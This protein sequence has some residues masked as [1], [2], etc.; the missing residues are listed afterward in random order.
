MPTLL[1][2]GD[3]LDNSRSRDLESLQHWV[4]FCQSRELFHFVGP[5]RGGSEKD[6]EARI[7][8]I[9]LLGLG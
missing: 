5:S 8:G 2:G 4:S 9:L 7:L 3:G 6:R 1:G